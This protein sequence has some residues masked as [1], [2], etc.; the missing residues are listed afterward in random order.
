VNDVSVEKFLEYSVYTG[1]IDSCVA[2]ISDWVKHGDRLR[3]L[4]CLN[5]PFTC[6]PAPPR[7]RGEAEDLHL[8]RT[9]FERLAE[10]VGAD[11]GNGDELRASS[12]SCRSAS[13][14]GVAELRF[15]FLLV[16]ERVRRIDNDVREP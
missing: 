16:G 14:H 13:H 3:W 15:L 5:P 9:P 12:P 4:A 7:P 2:A 8:H 10:D 11:R 6:L 1:K